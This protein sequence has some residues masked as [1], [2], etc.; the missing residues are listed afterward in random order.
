[1]SLLRNV[2]RGLRSLFRK[3]QMDRE[4]NEEMGAYLEMAAAE[5]MKDGLSHKEALRAVRL[6]QGSLEVTKEV[7]RSAGWE[8]FSRKFL[9]GLAPCNPFAPTKPYV[10]D[11][12]H[13]V[14][15]PRNRG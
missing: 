5:K 7:V 15:G 4:W 2:A 9:A 6:E 11:G 12:R 14:S 10:H 3:E 1:M 8:F 13:R